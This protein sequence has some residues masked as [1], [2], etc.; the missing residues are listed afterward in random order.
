MFVIILI[1]VG[2]TVEM[3]WS[4]RFMNVLC[5]W[6]KFFLKSMTSLIAY[7]LFFEWN[8]ITVHGLEAYRINAFLFNVEVL[9]IYKCLWMWTGGLE[10]VWR[11][12]KK[13]E[14][15]VAS[16]EKAS[17]RRAR[18]RTNSFNR[19]KKHWNKRQ[20]FIMNTVHICVEFQGILYPC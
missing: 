19:I 14:P 10:E 1:N 17:N 2:I 9:D 3:T 8:L 15:W 18:T 6:S 11:P 5:E 13:R 12:T 4:F 20:L 16:V 7:G